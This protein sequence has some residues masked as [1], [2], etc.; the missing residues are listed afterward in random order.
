LKQAPRAWYSRFAAYIKSLGFIGAKSDTSLFVF[1]RGSDTVYLLLYVDD[2]ILTASSTTLLQKVT[3]ALTTEFSMKDLG[4]LHHFLGMSVTRS[5]DGLQLSQRHYILEILD[6][7]GTSNY[8][9]CTTHV[10]TSAELS[11]DGNPMADAT[12]FRGLAGALQYLTFTRLD[13]TYAV[14]QVC[15]F[16]HDPREPHLALIK[17]ILRYVKGNL[18]H[19][20]WVHRSPSA[21]LVAYFDADWAGCP[22]TRRSTSGYVI[23]LGNNLISWS[24]KR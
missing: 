13:I 16:I 24:A 2:I 3:A 4:P 7:A 23:F 14:Q 17:R 6:H 9:P 19:G 20:L 11:P 10:D 12:H 21:D 8:K 18:D 22:E 1:R 15:L 5:A